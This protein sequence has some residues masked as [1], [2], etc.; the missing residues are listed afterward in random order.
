MKQNKKKQVSKKSFP[1]WGWILITLAVIAVA[2]FALSQKSPAPAAGLPPEISVD[3]AAQKRDQGALFWMCANQVSG[4]L[5]I[6]P[7]LPSS[8]WAICLIV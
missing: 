6:F 1:V 5:S 7:A 3:Q 2:G 4:L 8:P